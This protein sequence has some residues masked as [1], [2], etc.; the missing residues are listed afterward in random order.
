MRMYISAFF[1]FLVLP[2]LASSSLENAPYAGQEIGTP[3]LEIIKPK[4]SEW[5]EL[6]LPELSAQDR[7]MICTLLNI[8]YQ[9]ADA[10]LKLKKVVR[11]LFDEC[12]LIQDKAQRF[13]NIA[14]DTEYLKNMAA[15]VGRQVE[16][17]NANLESWNRYVNAVNKDNNEVVLK[18]LHEADR[19]TTIYIGAFLQQCRTTL[20]HELYNTIDANIRQSEFVHNISLSILESLR[21]LK[22]NGKDFDD[23]MS[24]SFEL[25]R[26]HFCNEVKCIMIMRELF[27]I[28]E[29]L[30]TLRKV[31]ANVFYEVALPYCQEC[32]QE[33][34]S[35]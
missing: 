12:C 20:G 2:I 3:L 19:I 14:E 7:A 26:V 16:A 17:Y 9:F 27:E 1:C 35:A 28:Q 15:E 22:D 18:V 32:E 11:K 4:A 5:A 8:S 29:E 13:L 34:I 24:S 21:S 23:I 25:A 30:L 6:C 31:V 10:D 33:S